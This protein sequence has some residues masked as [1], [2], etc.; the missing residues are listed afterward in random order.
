VKS[1]ALR[2][3]HNYNPPASARGEKLICHGSDGSLIKSWDFG[4]WARESTASG[5]VFDVER[6]ALGRFLKFVG[7]EMQNGGQKSEAG[8]CK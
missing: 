6:F 2:L 4:G 8:G 1:R 3:S 5:G 7:N